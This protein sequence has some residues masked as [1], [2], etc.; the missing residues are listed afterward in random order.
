MCIIS[1]TAWPLAARI[2][3]WIITCIGAD[4]FMVVDQMK[5]SA[6]IFALAILEL[7]R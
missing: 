1:R 3:E 2:P 4:E 7:C 5:K 6:V